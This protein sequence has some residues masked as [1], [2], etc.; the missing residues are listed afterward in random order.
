M[1]DELNEPPEHRRAAAEL[2]LG[3]LHA[4]GA[5]VWPGADGLTVEEVLLAYSQAVAAGRV[6][7]LPELLARH[8]G[9]AEELKHLV[10]VGGRG[11]NP[12]SLANR[13]PCGGWA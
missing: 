10:S 2:L 4:A 13:E 8:P 5:P 3:Y 11:L 12:G 1:R 9:L 6:P 7:A